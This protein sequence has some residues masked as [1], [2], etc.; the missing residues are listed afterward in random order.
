MCYKCNNIGHKARIS[1]NMEENAS[2]IKE[3]NLTTIWEKKQTSSKEDCKLA[4]I[5]ENKEDEW[6]INSGCSTHM[7]G[8]QN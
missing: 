2:I 7:T 4:L 8:D 3:E 1:R 6:Y 5:A